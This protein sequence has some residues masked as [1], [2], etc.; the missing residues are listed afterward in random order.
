MST[1]PTTFTELWAH[2]GPYRIRIR[3][4]PGEAPAIVL[5][6]GFPDD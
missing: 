5:M 1:Q 6:H 3:D 2:R 4:Y